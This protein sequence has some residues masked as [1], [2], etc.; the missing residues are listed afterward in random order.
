MKL[1]G[2]VFYGQV[3]VLICFNE[4]CSKYRTI[5]LKGISQYRTHGL[6]VLAGSGGGSVC[7][8]FYLN[9]SGKKGKRG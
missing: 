2:I 8:V 7:L 9:F 6:E 5:L 4:G 3:T 1:K